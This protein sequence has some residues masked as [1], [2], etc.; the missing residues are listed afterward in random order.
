MSHSTSPQT[1][2]GVIGCGILMGLLIMVAVGYTAIRFFIDQNNYN[3]GHRAYLQA[4][5]TQAIR[6]F[7]SVI[8][9]WRLVDIGGFPALAQQEKTECIPYQAAVEKQ[10]AGDF[11]TALMAYLNFIRGYS[12]SVLAA[13]ARN[14]GMSLFEQAQPS[15][16]AN[17]ETCMN[18][19]SLLEENLIPQQEVNLPPFYLSCGQVYD[20]ANNQQ[21]SFDMYKRLLTEYPNDL[22]AGEAETSLIANPLACKESDSLKN[23]VIAQRN[24]FMPSLYYHCGQAYD[25]ANDEQGSFAMYKA[26][27]TEYPSDLRAAE[28]EVS[29]L[30]NSLACKESDSLKNNVIAERTEFMPSLYYQCGQAYEGESDWEQAITMYENFLAEYPS[31]SLAPD[32]EAGLARSIVAQAQTTSAG[33]IPTPERSGSTGSTVTEV[34]IQN[35]SPEPLRIVF[36]GPESRVEEL[37]A[38]SSCTTYTGLGPLYCPEQGPIGRYRLTPGAYDVVVESGSDD[39]TTPWTGFWNLVSGD[40]YYSCFFIVTTFGQ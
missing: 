17:Q 38:C 5:C 21:S 20:S 36:S 2:R 28:A 27:L 26:L 30:A 25:A 33:E 37:E 16:L 1:Q 34:V 14:R 40:E 23:S 29:L 11:G 13:D 19:D 18:I 32:A 7:D 6:L 31:H 4:D 35:D 39:G 15:T 12:G 10:Q 22:L 9:G 3:K 8:N 24:E